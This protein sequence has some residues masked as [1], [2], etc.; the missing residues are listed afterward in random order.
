MGQT[1]CGNRVQALLT[2]RLW[3]DAVRQIALMSGLRAA[4]CPLGG[5][6]RVT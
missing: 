1:E 5:H 2:V 6:V 4:L 3:R